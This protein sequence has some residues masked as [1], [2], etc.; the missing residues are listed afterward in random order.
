VDFTENFRRKIRVGAIGL[1][2]VNAAVGLFAR[3]QQHAIID[4][5]VN[6]YDTAFVSTNYIHLAQVSFQHYVDERTGPAVKD[7]PETK[8]VLGNV[9]DNLDVAIERAESDYS[10]NLAKQLREKIVAIGEDGNAPD[11]KSHLAEI[12]K[13]LERAASR[14]SAVGLQA[15]DD[16][17]GFS[18]KSDLLLSMSVGISIV[19][20][21]IALFVLDRL[22]SQAQAAQKK[23]EQKDAEIEAAAHEQAVLREEE[24]TAKSRMADRMRELLESFTR[25]M[26]EP[27]EK[28]HVAAKDLNF[29]ADSLSEM[30]QQV[31]TQS[32]TVAAASEKTATMVKSAATAGE[33]LA[34]TIA[35]VES[36]AIESSRLAAGAVS[37]VKQTN[38]TMDE[39]AAVAN[40][41][42]Q[43]IILINSIAA[44]TNLLALNAT[45]EAARAGAAGRGF[46]VV[47]QEVKALA[48]QTANAT[49]D[50][51]DRVKAIQNV[52]RRSV[53]AIQSISHAVGELEGFSVRIASA[54]E[55]QTHAA[56][57]IAGN[58]SSAS[59]NVINV[60][61]AITKVENIGNRTAQAAATLTS[62]SVSVTSQAK[63]IHEQ[64]KAFTEDVRSIQARF[65]T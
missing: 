19:L 47:A 36:G 50:I 35:D 51:S 24:L 2:V 11:L 8:V 15:R 1:L 31:K 6:S 61:G 63:R 53:G 9:L 34:Q 33:E 39:L 37:E 3:Q 49:Q 55:Q 5:A 23:A 40:E 12:Q 42:S 25:E 41:I 14:A 27:T 20:V 58:L 57:E 46:A 16:I 7:M 29:S 48:A 64:V 60:H 45:I 59:D 54:V 28:L 22:I 18:S 32:V 65:G 43:V 10:R 13:E 44:Q 17:E 21:L 30:A 52:S 56:Q 26:A 4:Y 38:A 62:A